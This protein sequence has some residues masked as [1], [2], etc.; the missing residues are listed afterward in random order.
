MVLSALDKHHEAI[1][2]YRSLGFEDD[3]RANDTQSAADR[4]V[5]MRLTL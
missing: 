3:I 4:E 5:L 2:L 1:T